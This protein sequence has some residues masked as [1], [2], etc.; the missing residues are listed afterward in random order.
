M[1]V[2]TEDVL[3]FGHANSDLVVDQLK[4]EEIQSVHQTIAIVGATAK[5]PATPSIKPVSRLLS[6]PNSNQASP[7]TAGN[8]WKGSSAMFNAEMEEFVIE[9]TMEGSHCGRTYCIRAETEDE[10]RKWVAE[11]S[12]ASTTR[13][14]LVQKI[15]KRRTF[16]AYERHRVREFYSCDSVQ[17][18]VAIL[19]IGSF[20]VSLVRSEM[21]PSP[22]SREEELLDILEL[23][24]TILF[25][26]ELVVRMHLQ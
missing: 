4:L 9:T 16:L 25:A 26:I 1:I 22:E 11:I 21:L 5:V 18:S 17:F 12:M 6:K 8:T 23:I 19:I 7:S 24:F 2:L 15:H 14:K 13:I 10:C 20:A 3:A